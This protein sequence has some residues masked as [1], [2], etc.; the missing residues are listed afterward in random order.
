M[1][2]VTGVVAFSACADQTLSSRAVP[3]TLTVSLEMPA[4]VRAG[5]VTLTIGGTE[6][7]VPRSADRRYQ[8]FVEGV[9]SSSATIAVVGEHVFGP[10]VQVDVPDMTDLSAYTARIAEIVDDH[11]AL[12]P[13]HEAYRLI[14]TARPTERD[15][16]PRGPGSDRF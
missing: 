9:T 5:G 16:S 11:N 14:L 15:G 13:N 7:G 10:L 2:S 3:G 6:L 8:V 1:L 4:G 12:L